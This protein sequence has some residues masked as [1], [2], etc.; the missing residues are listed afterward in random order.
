MTFKYIPPS[1]LAPLL[2]LP[3]RPRLLIVDDQPINIQTLYRIFQSDHEIFMATDGQQALSLCWNGVPPDLILLDI[4]MPGLDGLTVCR[5]LKTNPLTSDIPVIFVTAQTDPNDETRALEAGGVDFITKP[6]NPAV[7]RARVKTHLTLKFQN[8]LLRVLAF[9][10]GLTGLANRRRFDETL[11]LEWRRCRRNDSPLALLMIDIDHFKLY[12]DRYGH[13]AGDSCLQAVAATLKAAFGRAQDLV[14]RYGGEEFVCL[15]PECD[16]A[17][18][19]PKAD[20]LVQAV[21]ALGLPH[22]SSPTAA[23]L[24]ISLGIAVIIPNVSRSPEDLV[25]AADAALYQAKQQGRN[26]VCSAPLS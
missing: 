6:V 9:I 13:Q 16:H 7:V 1:Q 11:Q 2:V 14:A 5:Q 23:T 19:K 18:A 20:A 4:V 15:L 25:M 17:A 8:D 10:D 24:T 12:N 21:A 26:Q 22:E 3:E